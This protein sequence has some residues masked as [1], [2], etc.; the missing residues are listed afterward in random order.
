MCGQVE[1]AEESG[2]KVKFVLGMRT[3]VWRAEHKKK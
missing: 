3:G 1:I 2:Q